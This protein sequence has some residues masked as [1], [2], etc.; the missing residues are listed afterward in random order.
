MKVRVVVALLAACLLS[1]CTDA[2]WDHATSYVGLGPAQSS[3][4]PPADPA[5]PVSVPT[6]PATKPDTWCQQI[7]ETARAD[8]AND[9]FDA[10]T[11]QRRA[12]TMYRQCVSSSSR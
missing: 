2:D 7:A 4:P 6:D 1:G 3:G 5:V 10:A 9:G 12:E 11:Q 8:A